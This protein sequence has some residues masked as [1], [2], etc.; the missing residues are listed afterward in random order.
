MVTLVVITSINVLFAVSSP[1]FKPSAGNPCAFGD[2]APEGPAL[3]ESAPL[4]V[5]V[6]TGALR[7]R[8]EGSCKRPRSEVVCPFFGVV[9][10]LTQVV[11]G[12]LP[13]RGSG[14]E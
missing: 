3:A 5:G 8:E 1:F 14:L 13:W 7:V 4:A 12:R 10:R 2:D 11:T 6:S 9:S